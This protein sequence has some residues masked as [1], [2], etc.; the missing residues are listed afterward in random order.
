MPCSG[1]F[2]QDQIGLYTKC[3]LCFFKGANIGD[4]SFIWFGLWVL[5]YDISFTV[6]QRKLITFASLM[7][8]KI[9]LFFGIVVLGILAAGLA[10]EGTAALG[11]DDL[12]EDWNDNLKADSHWEGLLFNQKISPLKKCVSSP[13]IGKGSHLIMLWLGSGGF[14]Q[15]FCSSISIKAVLGHVLINAP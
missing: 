5:F 11:M 12:R 14:L 3:R 9:K 6:L 2:Q 4:C 13:Y 10:F 1:I 8:H 7:D 15:G